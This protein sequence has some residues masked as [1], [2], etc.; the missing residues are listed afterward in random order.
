MAACCGNERQPKG[1]EATQ[2][3]Q[4]H[5]LCVYIMKSLQDAKYYRPIA[6]SEGMATWA[7]M[8]AWQQCS[9]SGSAAG[10]AGALSLPACSRNT[11]KG[12]K[13]CMRQPK[14]QCFP[15]ATSW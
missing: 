15:T 7:T 10:A 9:S 3:I 4:Q 11:V 1:R 5:F 8:V 6:K 13:W 14:L 2:V 12:D